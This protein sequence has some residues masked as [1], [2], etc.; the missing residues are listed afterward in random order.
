MLEHVKCDLCGSPEYETVW[1][2]SE[3]ERQGVLRSIVIRENGEIIQGEN[4][5]CNRCGLVYVTPRYTKESLAGFYATEYRKIY[6]GDN[7]LVAEQRHAQTAFYLLHSAMCE[8]E[9]MSKRINEAKLSLKILDVGCSTGKL[10]EVFRSG[11]GFTNR[12][13]GIE[14]NRDHCAR[15]QAQR[16]DVENCSIEEYA[17]DAK[18]DV[19]TMLN[20]LEHVTSPTGVLTKL[21]GFLKDGGHVLISVPNLLSTCINIPTDAFLSNAHL[22]NFTPATLGMML[23]KVGLKPIK[24]YPIAEEMGEKIYVLAEK[25]EPTEIEYDDNIEQRIE[26][27]KMFLEYA[28]RVF[29]MKQSLLNGI[30]KCEK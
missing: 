9:A 22:Y 23:A 12:I 29:V 25:S 28:D 8:K 24:M 13:Q 30:P 20:T 1:N 7:S 16:L 15:A 27:T 21:R 14:P 6:G 2:K 5:M 26:L 10:L 19:V 3:R 18:F 17:T 11:W 4:V